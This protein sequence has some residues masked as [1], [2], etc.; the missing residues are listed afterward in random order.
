MKTTYI[1]E[2]I[3]N[4]ESKNL[5][6]NYSSF[7]ICGLY[8]GTRLNIYLNANVSEL[9]MGTNYFFLFFF[10]FYLLFLLLWGGCL[11]VFL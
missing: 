5:A 1:T 11:F 3:K 9:N 2:L 7:H 4:T 8:I 10:V 6:V